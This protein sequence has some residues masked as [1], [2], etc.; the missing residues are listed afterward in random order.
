MEEM[1]PPP[2]TTMTQAV[3]PGRFQTIPAVHRISCSVLPLR[4][5]SPLSPTDLLRPSYIGARP[6][7]SVLS[8]V[9]VCCI[10]VKVVVFLCLVVTAGDRDIGTLPLFSYVRYDV[11]PGAHTNS[12]AHAPSLES[13]Q[14]AKDSASASQEYPVSPE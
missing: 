12:L 11:E 6:G 4:P 2:T 10:L 9:S 1:P 8:N 3:V 5:L 13:V 14:D 7:I